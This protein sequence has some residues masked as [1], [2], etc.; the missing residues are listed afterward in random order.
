MFL[1]IA[2]SPQFQVMLSL[3]GVLYVPSSSLFVPM[4]IV[5]PTGALFQTLGAPGLPPGFDFL[6][7]Y[8]Q[9]VWNEP[10][11]SAG[12]GAPSLLTIKRPVF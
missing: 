12:L 4:G 11:A 1:F 10:D 5:G 9:L 6:D 7:L 2:L 8:V 3:D